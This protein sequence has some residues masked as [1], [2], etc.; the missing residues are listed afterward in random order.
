[1]CLSGGIS[2]GVT[3]CDK[4]T[5]EDCQKAI[6]NMQKIEFGD[7]TAFDRTTDI[8]AETRRCRSGSSKE[9]VACAIAAKNKED[10]KACKFRGAK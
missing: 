2:V 1:M 9:A 4:P 8:S 5:P 6:E 3:G 7:V 10:L